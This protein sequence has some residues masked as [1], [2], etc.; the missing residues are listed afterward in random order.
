MKIV[1]HKFSLSNHNISAAW[2]HGF[3]TIL[4]DSLCLITISFYGKPASYFFVA[5]VV[6]KS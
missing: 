6:E 3:N 5:F 4:F 2:S 1:Q